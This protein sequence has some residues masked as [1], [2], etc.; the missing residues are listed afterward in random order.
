LTIKLTQHVALAAR[1]ARNRVRTH[2]TARGAQFAFPHCAT[3]EQNLQL[4]LRHANLDIR[5]TQCQLPSVVKEHHSN[6]QFP[7]GTSPLPAER[8]LGLGPSLRKIK[9]PASSAGRFR[10]FSGP[11][12]Q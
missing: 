3:L 6:Q 9:N 1:P 2:D 12:H 5:V 4:L 7:I 8:S 10:S 11:L